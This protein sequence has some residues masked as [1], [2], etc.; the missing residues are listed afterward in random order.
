MCYIQIVAFF[1]LGYIFLFEFPQILE[2]TA[3]LRCKTGLLKTVACLQVV[4]L[5][6]QELN[7]LMEIGP[8]EFSDFLYP[9][10]DSKPHFL[11][12]QHRSDSF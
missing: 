8:Q 7:K 5:N 9:E 6:K 3:A 1:V 10:D 4:L 2:T 11:S 12:E